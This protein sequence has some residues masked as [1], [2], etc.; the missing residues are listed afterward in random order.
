MVA[1]RRELVD[2]GAHE[3]A[4]L[5][6][7]ALL[8]AT[9]RDSARPRLGRRIGLRAHRRS[10]GNGRRYR[11]LGFRPVSGQAHFTLATRSPRHVQR[12]RR[13]ASRRR[14]HAL[15]RG[16][17]RGRAPVVGHAIRGFTLVMLSLS[18]L[19]ALFFRG[20]LVRKV[21]TGYS[22]DTFPNFTPNPW[23]ARAYERGEVEVEHWSFLAF[24]QRLEAAARGLPAVTTRSIAGSSMA[25][26]DA[27]ARVDTP[28]G[29]V[30]LLAPLVPDVALLHAPVADRDG[31]VALHPP[32][33]EGVWGALAARR[34]AI[35]TVEQVVDDLRP[36][37]HLVR[38]PAHRVLAVV[39]APM[40]A[41]PGGLYTGDLPVDGYGEDYD[42][43]VEARAATRAPTTTTTWIR[44]WVL[45]VEIAGAVARA[46]RRGARRAR[47]GRRPRPTR[48][49]PTSARTRPISTRRRT[50]GSAP[51][52]GARGTSPIASTRS[53]ADAVLAGAGV[54]NL[55][56]WLGVQL[57]RARGCDGAAHR[58]DRVV[59]LRRDARGSVRA[60]PPQLPDRD[61]AR[62]D[63]QTVLG[64]LV[65]GPGTTTIGCLGG[66]QIDRN[67]NVNSTWIPAETFPRRIGRRQ[68]RR[69]HRGRVR[70]GRDADA[71][72]H[73]GTVRLHHV[74]RAGRC[75]RSS[76]ISGR[77]RS[78]TA[79]W[80][81]P[82]CRPATTR[83]AATDRRGTRRVRVGSRRRRRCRRTVA[84]RARTKS[85]RCAGGTPTA[86]SFAR[87]VSRP[88]G[89]GRVR[90]CDETFR[91][92]RRGATTSISR[93]GTTSSSCSSARPAAA[94]PPPSGWSRG[95]RIRPTGDIRI[96]D[97][98]VN[99]VEPKDRDI[100]MVFQSYALYP[101]MTVARN[102]EFPLKS[103][104]MA[105]AE[106]EKLVTA[107]ADALGLDDAD[108]AQARAALRRSA[109]ARRA[110]AGDRPPPAGVPDGR[111]ALEPR[112]DA[113]R[114]DPRRA[115]R[116]ATP[117]R[118]DGDLRH[119]R[120]GRGDDDGS[121]HRD[122]ARRRAAAGRSAARGLRR[123]RRTCSS[124]ASSARRR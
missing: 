111:A 100:A 63:A 22:G 117:A 30:G 28:F 75:A 102:I 50:R 18:S 43:W 31:N 55:S 81:S 9:G 83:L 64:A 70:R 35:V 10:T 90:P 45:D 48:G 36:W 40:G 113:P 17:A 34:G 92:C 77:S 124:R 54:A 71:G 89:S 47:C 15:D 6:G 82:R 97:R 85:R 110:R 69:E 103:R 49:T 104:K 20:G 106:R 121:P 87:V 86:G 67:G 62:R 37:S 96:G 7:P 19:G 112:R 65:G 23:F 72:A 5:I 38:I 105:A 25:E 58:G 60:Q 78:A 98:V 27:Y 51:R 24:T 116:A 56:A 52:C 1:V 66:A 88:D 99:D 80:C 46:A 122:H 33:L 68:R 120:P 59:G 108:G 3:A 84:A 13:A 39:E 93:R 8:G 16:D 115:H 2:R 41:H 14:A 109:P 94:S 32:L 74:A 101:H 29:E 118:D 42:F 11:R 119:P 95:S 79:N 21:I 91:R 61:D 53:D 123:A 26:N 107:A 44:R 12:R 57:A 76:P 114:A 73:A 4:S